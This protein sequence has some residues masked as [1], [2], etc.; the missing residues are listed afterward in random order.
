MTDMRTTRAGLIM[1]AGVDTDLRATRVGHIYVYSEQAPEGG[2]PP[3][4]PGGPP[5]THATA[6][7]ARGGAVYLDSYLEYDGRYVATPDGLFPS[8][9][10]YLS[11]G[12]TWG[13][14]ESMTLHA[15]SSVFT[16]DDVGNVVVIHVTGGDKIR[17]AI[18]GFTSGTVVTG[19][20]NVAVPVAVQ[21]VSQGV[22][23]LAVD[24]VGGLEHLE[25]RD[26]GI[27]ADDHVVGS[28]NNAAIEIRTVTDGAVALGDFYSHV[29][30]GLAYLADLETLDID[31]PTGSTVKNSK[32]AITN[33]G[34]IVEKSR[35][36]WVGGQPPTDDSVDPLE[37]LSE[38]PAFPTVGDP[39]FDAKLAEYESLTSEYEAV[40]VDLTEWK[41]S[42]R[43]FIRSVDP[44]PA[45][46]LA[47]I[48]QGYIPPTQ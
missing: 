18:T 23:D 41:N 3:V 34:L 48:P 11:D 10:V 2:G 31:K 4:E 28:P 25:G 39:D 9:F 5:P 46:I 6:V 45:T 32:M 26:V 29:Y 22:W 40:N 19:T 24:V 42:G 1:V 33:V 38:L 44:V 7:Q 12:V 35:S 37:E 30:V 17:F 8:V 16:A 47:A 27:L 13:A 14:G 20:P 43:V 36:V 21:N 15:S